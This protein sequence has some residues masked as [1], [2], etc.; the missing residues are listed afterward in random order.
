MSSTSTPA[1]GGP[2]FVAAAAPHP[3]GGPRFVAAAPIP[4]RATSGAS[5]E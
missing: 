1:P 5:A 2:R 4:L 3:Q